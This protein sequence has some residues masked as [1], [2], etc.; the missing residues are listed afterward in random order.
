MEK[1]EREKDLIIF[2]EHVCMLQ[3]MTTMVLYGFSIT[4]IELI[5]IVYLFCWMVGFG[6]VSILAGKVKVSYNWIVINTATISVCFVT[7]ISYETQL[8]YCKNE[9]LLEG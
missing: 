3:F 7:R 5:Q 2:Y 4:P 1:Q 9:T 6:L 8:A